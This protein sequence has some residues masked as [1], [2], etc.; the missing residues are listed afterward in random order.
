M[1][2][3]VDLVAFLV[4]GYIRC[5]IFTLLQSWNVV[6]LYLIR[7]LRKTRV[8]LVILVPILVEFEVST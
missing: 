8:V 5:I 3:D 6:M 4:F 2:L 7:F 1:D